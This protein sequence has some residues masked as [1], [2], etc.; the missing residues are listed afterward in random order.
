M[1]SSDGAVLR[2]RKGASL[3]WLRPQCCFFLSR[4][5]LTSLTLVP[6]EAEGSKHQTGI[7]EGHK[8]EQDLK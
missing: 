2:R 4:L 8:D 1:A 3:C 7:S 5:S 6:T